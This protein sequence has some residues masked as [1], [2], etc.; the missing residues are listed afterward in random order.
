MLR[1]YQRTS[2]PEI[3]AEHHAYLNYWSKDPAE[4][5]RKPGTVTLDFPP[6]PARS[7]PQHTKKPGPRARGAPAPEHAGR[8]GHQARNGTL[9]GSGRVTQQNVIPHD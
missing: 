3:Q 9:T 8:F 1:A 6:A 2:V 5:N 7:T 4:R